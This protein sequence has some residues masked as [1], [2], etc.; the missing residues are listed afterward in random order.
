MTKLPFYKYEGTGNDFILLDQREQQYLTRNDNVI[1]EKLCDRRFGIGSD[2]VILLQ[3]VKKSLQAEYDFEMI[4]F[5]ASGFEGRMCGNGGRSIAAFAHFLGIVGKKI[6]EKYCF[7]AID[8]AHEAFVRE[9]DWVEVKMIDVSHVEIGNDHYILNTGAPHFV[10]FVDNLNE[11]NVYEKGR[12]IRYSDRFSKA[13]INVNFVKS[14]AEGLQMATYECGGEEETYSCGTGAT[15][16]A[17]ATHLRN[18][19]KTDIPIQM[20][21]GHLQVRFQPSG[22][23]CYAHIWL[24]GTAKQVFSGIILI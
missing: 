10:V 3:N 16:A 19:R 12:E 5:N 6:P 17:I 7:L 9:N 11:V 13:G 21:G 23:G 15:A 14:E 18:G 22:N 1:I 2:G 8:G 24:C 20:K 4:Y